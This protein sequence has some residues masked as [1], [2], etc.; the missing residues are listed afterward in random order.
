MDIHIDHR[1]LEDL[2]AQAQVAPPQSGRA[3]DA[4]QDAKAAL[5]AQSPQAECPGQLSLF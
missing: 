3:F 2:V 1:V 4:I 5:Q